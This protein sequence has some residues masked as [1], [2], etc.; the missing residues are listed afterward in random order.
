MKHYNPMIWLA[1]LDFLGRYWTLDKQTP[2]PPEKKGAPRGRLLLLW[3]SVV[4]DEPRVR[5]GQRIICVGQNP[6]SG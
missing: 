4:E 2:S 6:V 3:P 5:A 1:N